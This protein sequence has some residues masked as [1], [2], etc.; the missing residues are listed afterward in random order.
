MLLQAMAD[1]VRPA[2]H[3]VRRHRVQGRARAEVQLRLR[4]L[5]RHRPRELPEGGLLEGG[6]ARRPRAGAAEERL[7]VRRADPAPRRARHKLRAPGRHAV[8]PRGRQG[9][10]RLH[11]GARPGRRGVR[12]PA[13]RRGRRD[14]RRDGDAARRQAHAA[15]RTL[16][17]HRCGDR[18]RV[19][20]EERRRD[21]LSLLSERVQ[22]HVHR[23]EAPRRPHQPLHL[24][25]LL[26]EGHRR[27]RRRRCSRSSPSAR[28]SPQQFP[29][30]VDYESKQ[31][32]HA[33]LRRR[34]AC[35]TTGSP[36]KDV[37]VKKGFFG[38]T[39]RRDHA[40]VPAL[41]RPRRWRSAAACASASRACSTCTRRRRSSG[42]YF[43]ALG[44]PKQNVVFSDATTEE[45]W[46]E[47]G[48]Y[49]SIDPCYP[50]RSRRRTS[51]TCSSTT[52][53]REEAAQLHLLP[54]PHARA[55]LRAPTR[56]TTRAARSWP[57]RPT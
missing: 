5:P 50:S 4:R 35:P 44:I 11:Q 56:W 51:T 49:G 15:R 16:H 46:V 37:E 12:A 33:L 43:E 14:R 39:P 19:H 1:S 54:D 45:M 40:A 17:R 52:T 24:R 27:D 23:H 55:E 36:I 26:R 18:P 10:G 38:I 8:Q 30:L 32:V 7:A 22:A 53:R 25:L 2:G 41:E 29:N 34:A 3:R 42:T 48:K 28:R 6:A 21:R 9:A 31:R 47:G 20:D 57:A 13:H